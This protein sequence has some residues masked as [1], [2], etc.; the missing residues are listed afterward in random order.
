LKL[1]QSIRYLLSLIL[2]VAALAQPTT[3]EVE[4]KIA[5]A[6]QSTELNFAPYPPMLTPIRVGLATRSFHSKV[7][8]WVPGAV[9]VDGQPVFNLAAGSVYSISGDSISELATGKSFRLPPG[10]RAQLAARDYIVWVNNRW[11]R[12]SL[13]LISFAGSTTIINLLDLENY[14]RGVVPAE[15]P[16]N[17]N[18]EALKAQA[19]AARSYAW[20]HLGQGSK[21][22]K[23]EGYDLVPD[24][25]DQMYKG[26]AA[27]AASTTYA[28]GTTRGVV[29]RDSGR[30]KP[31]FY[32]A[33]VGDDFENLNIR[34]ASVPKAI[35]EKITGVPKIVG[36]T[37]KQWDPS[38]GNA[39]SLQV[40]GANKKT[41]E[42]SGVALARM[43]HFATAG[44][45][46]AREEGSNWIFTYRGPG[47]GSRGLSQ[48]GANML[49]SH[50]WK[51]EQ[52][53]QQYYQDPSGRVRLDLTDS[54]KILRQHCQAL[55][56]TKQAEN[57]AVEASGESN[58]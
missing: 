38:N 21:W 50:G 36:V 31:G 57:K 49:A 19:I 23:T 51:C 43:L 20:A 4:A 17:W 25:R 35:L 9:F 53:L 48:H 10:K 11:Y 41:R 5:K 55:T 45:L 28:V 18:F 22:F 12:G 40:M 3:L 54:E 33:W 32:R 58:E 6:H 44:I 7:A 8:V 15:M 56:A 39:H 2:F 24:V 34:K 16:A 42:V 52:I 47:N 30:V 1:L 29:L 26:L 13:E 27:E 37:V 46:D 14:L